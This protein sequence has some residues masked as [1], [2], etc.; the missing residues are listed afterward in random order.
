MNVVQICGPSYSGSTVLGYMLNT[1]SNVFFGSEVCMFL[2]HYKKQMRKAGRVFEPKCDVCGINC[3][4]W[5]PDFL[6]KIEEENV[7]NLTQLYK[8]LETFMG[9]STFIDGSKKSAY[10]L[11]H[12]HGKQVISAKHPL[13]I[14]AS[15][16]YNRR[17]KL[18]IGTDDFDEFKKII[19][20]KNGF[21]IN[22]LRDYLNGLFSSYNEFIK[23]AP[24]GM[25]CRTDCLLDNEFSH[26]KKICRHLNIDFVSLDVTNF[27]SY[28]IHPIGGNR[29]PYWLKAQKE[30]KKIK[31]KRFDYYQ[32]AKSCGDVKIDDKYNRVFSESFIRMLQGE[33]SYIR[34]CDLL[35]YDYNL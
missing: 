29:A 14:M 22:Y 4:F 11:G 3:N 35:G 27:S 28:D 25:V 9:E 30:G 20:S 7:A 8:I 2:K 32:N 6:R 26:L 24:D 33:D 19:D 31:D 5:T 16:I 34:L 12:Y 21:F 15:V 13:R 23:T 10:Y 18:D 1:S 17:T